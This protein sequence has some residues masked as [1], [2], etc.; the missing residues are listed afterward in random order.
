M[1]GRFG[2]RCIPVTAAAD[3]KKQTSSDKNVKDLLEHQQPNPDLPS[4]LF[5]LDSAMQTRSRESER[6]GAHVDDRVRGRL[7]IWTEACTGYK[8]FPLIM[9]PLDAQHSQCQKGRP[10]LYTPIS[11]MEHLLYILTAVHYYKP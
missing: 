4:T 3:Y 10:T 8:D 2:G 11:S 9:K 6:T 5:F 7:R 1:I